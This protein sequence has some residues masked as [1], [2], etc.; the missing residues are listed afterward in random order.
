MPFEK[1]TLPQPSCTGWQGS[2]EPSKQSLNSIT[3]I[4]HHY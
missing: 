2:S 3:Y 1:V 4:I